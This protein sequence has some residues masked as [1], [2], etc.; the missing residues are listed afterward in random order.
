VEKGIKILP[1]GGEAPYHFELLANEYAISN[2]TGLFEWKEL[3][4][5]SKI[6]ITDQC[7]S[8]YEVDIEVELEGQVI[9][10]NISAGEFTL[11]VEKGVPP[12]KFEIRSLG[13]TYFS[14]TGVFLDLP[15]N[16][17]YYAFYINDA[18]EIQKKIGSTTSSRYKMG[19]C[20]PYPIYHL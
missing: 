13:E 5:N 10:S 14:D 20:M 6:R 15:T 11:A 1:K 18:C 2:T 16:R 17:S 8:T 7:L 4:C 9:C 3:R 19:N 12:Y